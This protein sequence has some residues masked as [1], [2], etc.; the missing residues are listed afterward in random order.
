MRKYF[1]SL[2]TGL[3]LLMTVVLP[4]LVIKFSSSMVVGVLL[5]IGIHVFLFAALCALHGPRQ[6]LGRLPII[7]FVVLVVVYS[8]GILSFFINTTFN[9][10][11]FVQ[12][13]VFLIFF[14]LGA[15]FL[16]FL[17][18]G[19]PKY[20]ADFAVKLVFYILILNGL[21][22]ILGYRAMGNPSAVGFFSENSHYA[23]SFLPFLYYMV[24]L[25]SWR[26]KW[27]LL[28]MGFFIAFN[29]E[30]V[31]LVFGVI[32]VAILALRLRQ[33]V[34]LSI[35]AI[36]ILMVAM[37]Y[38]DFEYYSSRLNLTNPNMSMLSFLNGWE[39]AYLNLKDS[40]G[41]GLGL[42]QLGVL[43]SQ[44][45]IVEQIRA[46]RAV[47]IEDLNLF[48]GGLVAS[49]FI[50][51]F[52]ILAVMVLVAYLVHFVRSLRWLHEVSMNGGETVDCRK[53]FFLGCFVMFFID[54]FLRGTGYFSSS[55]FL[56]V[57]SLVWIGQ[58]P[59]FRT[60]SRDNTSDHRFE[61]HNSAQSLI[62]PILKK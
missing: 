39:R 7:F 13:Y 9:I 27:L 30:S 1:A 58:S 40:Y 23:H 5:V 37:N 4:S 45:I 19:L 15:S 54:L 28:F 38:M 47:G 60:P 14:V 36:P 3:V 8:Q 29:L 17:A 56:F 61:P 18:Q 6:R 50:S 25:S 51:E 52:G 42:Q 53:V 57:A 24:V 20:K 21:V 41:I 35:I 44:G 10:D 2:M 49:K 48:D 34:F 43:G 59:V 46:L 55:G 62:V 26:K 31:T 33:L 22:T 16:A 12:S 32:S 11:R